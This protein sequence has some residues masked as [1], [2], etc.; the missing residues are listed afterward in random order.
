MIE[1]LFTLSWLALG[2]NAAGSILIAKRNVARYYLFQCVCICWLLLFWEKDWGMVG[3][4]IFFIM[5]NSYGIYNW[6][7]KG[8]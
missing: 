6:R 5:A 7:K 3:Q 1:Q 8:A 4:V 2:F